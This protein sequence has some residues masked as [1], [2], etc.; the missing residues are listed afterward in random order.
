MQAAE[1]AEWGERPHQQ[2]VAE[3]TPTLT[4]QQHTTPVKQVAEYPPA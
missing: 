3:I 1:K 2:E 4:K